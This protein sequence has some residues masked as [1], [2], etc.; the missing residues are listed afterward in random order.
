[1]KAV[2]TTIQNH[3]VWI[4]K[5]DTKVEQVALAGAAVTGGT[6]AQAEPS[7]LLGRYVFAAVAM[8]DAHAEVYRYVSVRLRCA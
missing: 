1:M 5:L 3:S 8:F 4:A 7:G 6:E 2:M